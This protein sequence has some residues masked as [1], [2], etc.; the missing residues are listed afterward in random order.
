MRV[1]AR[2]GCT[3]LAVVALVVGGLVVASGPP[4]GSRSAFST[5]FWCGPPLEQSTRD[6]FIQVKDAGFT[7]SMPPCG[8]GTGFTVAENIRMLDAAQPAGMPTFVFD[9]RMQRALDDPGARADL[10]DGIVRAYRSH[11]ALGGYYVYDEVPP[12]D[13]AE[14]AAVVA[15]L[16]ARDPLHPAFVSLFPNYAPIP[17]Y[18]R[19]VRDFVR[20]IHPSAIVYDYYPFLADGS[21]RTGFFVNLRSIRKVALR[22]S[23]PFWFFAQLTE[24]P[25]LR[26]ASESEKRWQALQT[27]AYGARGLMFFTYWSSVSAEFPEP[28]VIDPRTGLPTAHY[29]EVLR[30]NAQARGFGRALAAARSRSVFHNGPLADGAVMRPPG[31]PVYFPSRAPITTGLFESAAYRYAMFASRD[32]RAAVSTKAVL[33]FG[34]RWPE[35][36]D[37]A[38]GRWVRVRAVRR[39]AHSVTIRLALQPAGGALFRIRKAVPSGPLG[40][41]AVFGR[42]RAN[43]GRWSLVDSRETTYALRGAGWREC[44][45]G[46]VLVGVKSES[47]GFWLCARKDLAERVFYVGN[48]VLGSARY[49]RVR[50][51]KVR[52]LSAVR[53]F[54]CGRRS[55]LLGR[56]VKPNGFWLCL[57]PSPRMR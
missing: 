29:A 5:G 56:L 4:A 43:L 57:G 49:Y 19:Y 8:D 25:G 40:A 42:V 53:R 45:S 54:S 7:F 16:R 18:D 12:E 35:R 9:D 24:I 1:G 6:R 55:R 31:A 28:G 51:G 13:V 26:R 22:S 23:T 46:F 32:Y 52:R 10:L 38:S 44:P 50:S 15:G 39:R 41:E 11:P 3:I 36:L 27:L 47:N 48:V 14:T 37:L 21:D 30:V 34:P 33:S 17:D 2:R 20:Q